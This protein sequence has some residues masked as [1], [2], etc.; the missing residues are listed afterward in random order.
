MELLALWDS[1]YTR[2]EPNWKETAVD[3]AAFDDQA[4][5]EWE[6]LR[7]SGPRWPAHAASPS[8]PATPV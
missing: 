1:A 3:D 2:H 5:M 6:P 4:G 7:R 8:N